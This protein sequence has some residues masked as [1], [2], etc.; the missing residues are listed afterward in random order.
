MRFLIPLLFSFILI[1]CEVAYSQPYGSSVFLNGTNNYITIPNNSNLNQTATISVEAWIYPCKVQ[2]QNF[3]LNKDWCG[4]SGNNAYNFRVLNGK[5][6]WKW[7]LDGCGNG[8][9][10]YESILPAIQPNQWQHVVAV[11]T[12]S[13]VTLYL[14]GAVLPGQLISGSYGTIMQSPEPVRIGVYRDI[15]SAYWGYFQGRIDEVRVWNYALSA[16]EVL[17]RYNTTL[18]GNETGLVAYYPMDITGSGAGTLVPNQATLTGSAINGT[19]VGTTSSPVFSPNSQPLVPVNLGNDTSLCPGQQISLNASLSGATYLWQ[20]NSTLPTFQVTQPGNYWVQVSLGG[21]A[22]TDTLV[23]LQE[24]L[25]VDLGPDTGLCPGDILTLNATL[26]GA[27]YLWDNGATG[28]VRTITQPGTYWVSVSRNGCTGYDSISVD[29]IT[30]PA[31]DLGQDTSI[32]EGTLFSLSAGSIPLTVSLLWSTGA[33][34]HTIYPGISGS[35]WLK[36]SVG[37]C[38]ESDTINVYFKP[39]PQTD[40]GPDT[41]LCEGDQIVLD[42]FW[43]GGLY[44]WNDGSTNPTLNI[45][46]AGTYSVT[47]TADGCINQ[48]AIAIDTDSVPEVYLGDDTTICEGDE[49]LLTAGNGFTAYLWNT[50]VTGNVIE[51]GQQGA[52]WVNVTN[53]CG[54]AADTFQLST[55]DCEYTI[56]IPNTFTPWRVDGINDKFEV[57]GTAIAEYY[58]IIFNRWGGQLYESH[59]LYEPWDGTY[60]GKRCPQSVYYYRIDFR[61]E[62]TNRW[63]TRQGSITLL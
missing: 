51:I 28:P 56:Y 58:I 30:L 53:I 37:S 16:T 23:V 60:H 62:R 14:N 8:A 1:A 54:E 29:F 59:S 38:E 27:T 26:P 22:S 25:P 33:T 44:L 52:Y 11:H 39:L 4:G 7:D 48:D 15:N 17:A 31:I 50:G 3:I 36:A 49:I 20:N 21:C 2:G 63:Y 18:V 61:P 6:H 41:I 12:T 46:L 32:C 10:A 5:L 47:V 55:K 19:T 40:L 57:K 43:P 24:V 34:S 45:S 9:H 42:A 35:Y 13:S